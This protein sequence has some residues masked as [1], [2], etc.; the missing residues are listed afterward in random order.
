MVDHDGDT[1][2]VQKFTKSF[3][4]NDECVYSV[5]TSQTEK[6]IHITQINYL[7]KWWTKQIVI[8]GTQN[9]KANPLDTRNEHHTV[10]HT[11]TVKWQ[12]NKN[13]TQSSGS[14]YC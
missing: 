5:V 1:Q 7:D 4:L 3:Y 12:P 11:L 10:L 9:V 6:H 2:L 8:S 14:D 13:K